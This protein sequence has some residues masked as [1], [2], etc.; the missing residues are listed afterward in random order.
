MLDEVEI[1]VVN[2]N[3]KEISEQVRT[4][5]PGPPPRRGHRSP[6]YFAEAARR[7]RKRKKEVI[8]QLKDENSRLK[9]ENERL[10]LKLAGYELAKFGGRSSSPVNGLHSSVAYQEEL[11]QK[12]LDNGSQIPGV[13]VVKTDHSCFEVAPLNEMGNADGV[14]VLPANFELPTEFDV[15]DVLNEASMP[16]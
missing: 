4:E 10:K 1:L 6:E 9:A 12:I 2:S 7:Y 8:E 13:E 11:A 15:I 16:L 5:P 3:G 14:A